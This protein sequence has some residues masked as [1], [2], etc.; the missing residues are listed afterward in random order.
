[1]LPSSINLMNKPNHS[2]AKVFRFEDRDSGRY[3]LVKVVG[4]SEMP[5]WV[6]SDIIPILYPD[7][8][9]EEYSNYLAQIPP[10][11]KSQKQIVTS[12]GEQMVSTLYESG[13]NYLI[14]RSDSPLMICFQQW[15][16]QEILPAIR[17]NNNYLILN[18]SVTLNSNTK[19]KLETLRLGMDL[20]YE[21]GGVDE[22][23]RLVLREK[24]RNLLLEDA[25]DIKKDLISLHG[26]YNG[27]HSLKSLDDFHVI[28]NG[29]SNGDLFRKDG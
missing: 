4:T 7:L 9:K 29:S 12:S 13:L 20:L 16:S 15:V 25:E 21:L 10:I 1:M 28:S 5:E 22:Y 3:W 2:V 19:E 6:F 26:N 14:A 18:Q 27:N 23:M 11:W 8:D 24:V 17:S